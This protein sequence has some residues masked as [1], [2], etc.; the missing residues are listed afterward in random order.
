MAKVGW[1]PA[2]AGYTSVEEWLRAS[3][4]DDAREGDE[5]VR[6]GSR[7]RKKGRATGTARDHRRAC[8]EEFGE[9]ASPAAA[10]GAR[11]A[12]RFMNDQ[13]LLD[14][15][16][17]MSMEDM[18]S[19]FAPVPWGEATPSVFEVAA[20]QGSGWDD[21]Y[22]C[23]SEDEQALLLRQLRR[24]V[25]HHQYQHRRESL[26]QQ[27]HSPSDQQQQQ[28]QQLDAHEQPNDSFRQ[29]RQL[30]QHAATR[31][32]RR[33]RGRA[34]RGALRRALGLGGHCRTAP[35]SAVLALHERVVAF[36]IGQPHRNQRLQ[37]QELE[38]Q[39]EERVAAAH[40]AAAGWA[41][42]KGSL[43]SDASDCGLHHDEGNG[44][45]PSPDAVSDVDEPDED[46]EDDGHAAEE[47]D[48]GLDVLVVED[49]SSAYARLLLH[50][51]CQFY[52]LRSRTCEV[53]EGEGT[54]RVD[55]QIT[56]TQRRQPAMHL[57]D[58]M[59][60]LFETDAATGHEEAMS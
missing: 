58:C 24:D 2:R 40:T 55:V 1:T 29:R 50:G 30:Q 18:E 22:R 9:G 41:T 44:V 14:L 23:L 6:R 57:V 17:P 43:E 49:L 16:G 56:R 51:M 10:M 42:M 31:A 37:K 21:R 46:R 32:W 33:V 4:Y 52:G 8:Y 20:E 34:A 45:T 28:Q 15:A 54:T 53:Q 48:G 12:R 39:A 59:R 11:R 47:G 27:P 35:D 60:L 25:R 26:P 3:P 7:G 5:D 13:L 19:L 36:A 38:L